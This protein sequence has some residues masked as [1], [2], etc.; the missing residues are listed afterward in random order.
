VIDRFV[1]IPASAG[2]M[3][4]WDFRIP[5]ANSR[6]NQSGQPRECVYIGLLPHIERNVKY[7]EDQL[8]RY[9]KGLVPEDQWHE[10]AEEDRQLCD[11]E[12]SELGK[13][14][15]TISPYS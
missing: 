14:L 2:D 5:H 6:F 11:Y 3:V 7:V 10:H 8:D 13:K 9:R 4:C 12:F 1:S 15:M